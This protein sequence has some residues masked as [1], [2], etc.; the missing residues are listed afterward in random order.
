[1]VT[2]MPIVTVATAD[3]SPDTGRVWVLIINEALHFGSR[4]AKTPL[5]PNQLQQNGIVL[6]DCPRQFD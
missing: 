6:E 2:R 3:D 5:Y 1:M 4:M